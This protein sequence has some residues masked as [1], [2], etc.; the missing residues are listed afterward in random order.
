MKKPIALAF[1]NRFKMKKKGLETFLKRRKPFA[2]S[3]F[4]LFF[5]MR[6]KR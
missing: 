4:I 2:L 3:R 6:K 5:R 1:Q